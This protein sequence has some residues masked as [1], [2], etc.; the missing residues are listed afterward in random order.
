MAR[1]FR[2]ERDYRDVQENARGSWGLTLAGLL[3]MGVG[4][5]T[6]RVPSY[7]FPSP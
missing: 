1:T 4:E 3:L 6:P 2:D 5:V 7:R